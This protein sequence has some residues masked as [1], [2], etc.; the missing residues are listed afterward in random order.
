MKLLA[1]RSYDKSEFFNCKGSFLTSLGYLVE[2]DDFLKC[3][4]E[5]YQCTVDLNVRDDGILIQLLVFWILSIILCLFKSMLHR[6]GI[7]LLIGPN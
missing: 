3:R 1:F 4:L 6:Q 5:N 7:P 2:F